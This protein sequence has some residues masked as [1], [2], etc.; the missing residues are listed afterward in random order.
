MSYHRAKE[1]SRTTFDHL[2]ANYENT[3]VGRHSRRVKE[4]AR[5]RLEDPLRGSLLDIGCDPRLPLKALAEQ[6]PELTLAG[7]TFRLR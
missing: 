4:T 1:Q 7:S 5:R 3:L 2:A 6:D